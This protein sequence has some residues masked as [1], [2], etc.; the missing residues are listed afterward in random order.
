MATDM[1]LKLEGIEGES[2]DDAHKNEIQVMSFDYGA[3]QSAT[4]HEGGGSTSGRADVHDLT[5]V[6]HVDKSSPVLFHYCASGAHIAK[7]TLSVRKSAG[8]KKVD[9]L[10][11]TMEQVLISSF[12]SGAQ[13]TA[14]RVTETMVLNFATIKVQYTPQKEDGTALA[15]TEKGWHIAKNI[16]HS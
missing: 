13:G 10:V 7:A 3:T 11:L 9:Y 6:K 2:L 15:S 1:Y 4:A 8:A 5:V 14:D 16:D 12:K